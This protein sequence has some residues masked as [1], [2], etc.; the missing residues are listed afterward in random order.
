ML[1]DGDLVPAWREIEEHELLLTAGT[2]SPGRTIRRNRAA[3]A[4]LLRCRRPGSARA[5]E[6]RRPAD[7]RLVAQRRHLDLTTGQRAE[8]RGA[9]GAAPTG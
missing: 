2:Q 3:A 8:C 1:S 7:R 4:R 6:E 5:G 9:P